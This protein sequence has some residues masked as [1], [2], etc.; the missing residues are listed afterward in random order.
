M[1]ELAIALLAVPVLCA[2]VEWRLGLLL[3]LVTAILQD[4]LRKL[5]PDQPVLFVV[6]VGIVFGAAC[7]GAWVRG[8]QLVPSSIFG[9]RRELAIPF[10]F[11]VLLIIMQAANA[12]VHTQNVMIPLTG[13]LAY[14]LPFPSIVFGYQL[15]FREGERRINQFMTWYVVCI[16]L[17]L[18]TVYLEFSGYNWSILGQVG[19]TFLVYDQNTH[20][21]VI[22]AA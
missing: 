19:P 20:M 4:P 14:L 2:F 12:F 7:V 3:C 5:T 17:A 8:V 9:W 22:S 13:L 18:M 1:I 11:W 10:S 6:F 16:T 21:Q 15:T